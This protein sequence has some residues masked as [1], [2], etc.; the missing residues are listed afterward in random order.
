MY[1]SYNCTDLCVLKFLGFQNHNFF[2]RRSV[3]TRKISESETCDVQHYL[4][5][6]KFRQINVRQ[7][8]VVRKYW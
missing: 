8:Y 1:S 3:L 4:K 2:L 5:N 7:N 6:E